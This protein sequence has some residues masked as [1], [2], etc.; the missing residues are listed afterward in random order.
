MWHF[1]NTGPIFFLSYI[2]MYARKGI[3][4]GII[5]SY[6]CKNWGHL[7]SP[8]I[9]ALAKMQKEKRFTYLVNLSFSMPYLW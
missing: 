1:Y 6:N 7:Y 9:H 8:R 4:G 5:V 3:F 2:N